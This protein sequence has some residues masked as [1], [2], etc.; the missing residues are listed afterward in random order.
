MAEPTLNVN[1]TETT[2]AKL[3]GQEAIVENSKL[4]R[5]LFELKVKDHTWKIGART[6][7]ARIFVGLLI[8][9]NIIVFTLVCIAYKTE[10]LKNLSLVFSTLFTATLVE[11]A[12]I[13]RIIVEWLFS[14]IDYRK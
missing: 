5:E 8:T 10:T 13:I 9:Q 6:I 11:T 7:Y 3:P 4:E 14:D 2:A 1:F 12:Y